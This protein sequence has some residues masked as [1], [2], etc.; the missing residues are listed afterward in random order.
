MKLGQ[1]HAHVTYFT[2][3]S[4]REYVT[5]LPPFVGVG[6]GKLV[7]NEITALMAAKRV[8]THGPAYTRIKIV[9]HDSCSSSILAFTD[10]D[11]RNLGYRIKIKTD[12]PCDKAD[13][14]DG[15]AYASKLVSEI[16]H[17]AR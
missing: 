13:G 17:P 15:F 12:C 7:A 9:N 14:M 11:D 16:I 8:E 6:V 2:S 1:Y 4:K 3:I 5:A 10:K